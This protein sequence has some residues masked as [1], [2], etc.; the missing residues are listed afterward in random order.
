VLTNYAGY[1]L[2]PY[3]KV[4]DYFA[5]LLKLSL[6]FGLVFE[7]PVVSFV[8]VRM[9]LL[10]SDFLIRHVRIAIVI[11]FIV[12]AILTPPDVFSQLLLALPLLLLYG[13]SIIVARI[14]GRKK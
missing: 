12:A 2:D 10:T 11:I 6:A 4:N 14:A 3:F 9:G 5:F 8:L 7:L 13:L 1:R